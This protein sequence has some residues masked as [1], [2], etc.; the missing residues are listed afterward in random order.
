MQDA[1]AIGEVNQVE[2][3]AANRLW[4]YFFDDPFHPTTIEQAIGA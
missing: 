2:K 1:G 4:E 3:I